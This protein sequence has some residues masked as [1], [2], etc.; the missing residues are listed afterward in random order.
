MSFVSRDGLNVRSFEQS[1]DCDY[2][3]KTFLRGEL[4]RV[5]EDWTCTDGRRGHTTATLCPSCARLALAHCWRC[6]ALTGRADDL[7]AACC[8]DGAE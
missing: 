5:V 4:E 2:C 7:C 3:G 1:G 8:E 6:G